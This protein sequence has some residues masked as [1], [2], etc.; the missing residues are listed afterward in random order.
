MPVSASLVKMCEDTELRM[1]CIVQYVIEFLACNIDTLIHVARFLLP[2]ICYPKWPMHKGF[3]SKNWGS[4]GHYTAAVHVTFLYL[5]TAVVAIAYVCCPQELG[6]VF[7][8]S[9]T[10]SCIVL[11]VTAHG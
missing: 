4:A 3:K 6:I 2:D 7:Q 1:T 5:S 10:G 9:I 11:P 8:H